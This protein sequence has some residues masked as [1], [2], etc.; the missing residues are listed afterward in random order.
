[1]S[2]VGPSFLFLSIIVFTVCYVFR[3][4]KHIPV[5]SQITGLFFMF[6]A[7]VTCPLIFTIFI[8][9]PLGIDFLLAEDFEESGNSKNEETQNDGEK[10]CKFCHQKIGA[11]EEYWDNITWHVHKKCVPNT[12]STYTKPCNPSAFIYGRPPRRR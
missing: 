5:L 7:V 11:H 8:F 3:T 4:G 9:F 2:S 10:I 12:T 1:M 6:L